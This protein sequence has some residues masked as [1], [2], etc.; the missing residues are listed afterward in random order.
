MAFKDT[1]VCVKIN[2]LVKK[3]LPIS[4]QKIVDEYI[5]KTLDV[6]RTIKNGKE[7]VEVKNKK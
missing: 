6:T 2:A 4:A 1:M 7:K 3:M 5:E